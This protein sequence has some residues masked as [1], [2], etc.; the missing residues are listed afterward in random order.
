MIGDRGLLDKDSI[1]S[2]ERYDRRT[3]RGKGKSDS[4]HANFMQDRIRCADE[5]I[6]SVNASKAS[7]KEGVF[8][9][10]IKKIDDGI[11]S[12]NATLPKHQSY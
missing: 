3:K 11:V 7:S 12:S 2:T 10:E 1:K 8:F 6:H 9:A 5:I 4:Y